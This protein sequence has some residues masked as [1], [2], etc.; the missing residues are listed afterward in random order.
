M[1]ATPSH[2]WPRSRLLGELFIHMGSLFF[3]RAQEPGNE[4]IVFVHHQPDRC[5]K[6]TRSQIASLQLHYMTT[7]SNEI[8]SKLVPKIIFMGSVLM[9]R[10]YTSGKLLYL[11]AQFQ[12]LLGHVTNDL[13][14]KMFQLR[15]QRLLPSLPKVWVGWER[16]YEIIVLKVNL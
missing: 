1:R 10:N 16:D 5:L 6:F 11:R 7:C 8:S 12:K 13:M 3:A 2:I 14:N 9:C 15:C 4:A